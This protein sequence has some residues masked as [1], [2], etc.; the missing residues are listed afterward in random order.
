MV[1]VPQ[2]MVQ[3]ALIQLIVSLVFV[4][5]MYV[6]GKNLVP[7]VQQMGNVCRIRVPQPVKQLQLVALVMKTLA[8]HLAGVILS[9]ALVLLLV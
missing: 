4:P 9:K 3:P 5:A 2:Q 8:V 1:M 6:L 7:I